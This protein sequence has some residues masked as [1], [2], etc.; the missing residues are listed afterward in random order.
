MNKSLRQSVSREIDRRLPTF[1]TS[2]GMAYTAYD[3]LRSIHLECDMASVVIRFFALTL[4]VV[5]VSACGS[6]TKTSQSSSSPSSET[7][8]TGRAVDP[9]KIATGGDSAK[10]SKRRTFAPVEIKAGDQT[11]AT[12][13]TMS[14]AEQLDAIRAALKPFQILLGRWNGLST[15]QVIDHPDWAYDWVSDPMHPGLRVKSEKGDY[16]R[17]G[18]LSYLPE[19][20][21]FAFKAIDADGVGRTFVGTFTEPVRDV[22]GDEK[23]LQRTYKLQLTEPEASA[24]GE[25]WRITFNQQ[26]NNRYILE[27]ERKRGSGQFGRV[28]TIGTQREGTSF[29]L[30]D[31][32]Y[33]DKTCIISQGLGTISVSYKG[34]SYWVCCSGCK[35]AFEDEPEKWI[36]KWEEKKKAMVK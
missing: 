16:I 31:T 4:I 19:S 27:F 6:G 1:Q 13:R 32:D 3:N 34:Q 29:A 22:A 7:T 8:A 35:A 14:A 9:E 23:K 17:E 18:R 25:Q 21:Q 30:S 2:R 24:A 20:D 33:G 26:E 5:T 28:D 12:T 36:A 10:S 15:R 11:A